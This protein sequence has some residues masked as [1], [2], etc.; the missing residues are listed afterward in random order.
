M[1]ELTSPTATEADTDT[2]PPANSAVDAAIDLGHEQTAAER[3]NDTERLG[4]DL[5]DRAIGLDLVDRAGSQKQ[6]G[7]G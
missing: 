5:V 4:I 2:G 3:A 6:Q 7:S 1:P